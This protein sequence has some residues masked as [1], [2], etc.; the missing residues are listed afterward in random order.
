MLLSYVYALSFFDRI[1]F[2]LGL[3]MFGICCKYLVV[4]G[5]KAV[6]YLDTAETC[7]VS[8]VLDLFLFLSCSSWLWEF[9]S[10]ETTDY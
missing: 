5:A 2:P 1:L 9:L 3:S 6:R 10:S 7:Y 4:F 8:V